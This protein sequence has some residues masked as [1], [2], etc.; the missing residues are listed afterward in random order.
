[1]AGVIL[2]RVGGPRHERYLSQALE[3]SGAPPLLGVV[4]RD[5]VV[6]NKLGICYQK[7]DNQVAARREYRR[8][9][10]LNPDYAEVWNNIG[11]LNQSADDLEDA[12]KAYKEAIRIK[13]DLATAW[14]NL[15]NAYLALDRPKEAFEAYQEAF[16]L[17]P[18]I[19]ETRGLGIPAGVDAAMPLFYLAKL[20]AA[21]GNVDGAL[22]F[23]ARAREAGFDDFDRVRSDPDFLPVV[24]D[25]RFQ[26]LFGE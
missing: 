18:T 2:N 11:T 3:S 4:P 7:I 26:T 16:R 13:P 8:A 20:L 22:E 12:V 5:A 21:N 1:M 19:L 6:H 10:A 23:L 17:D 25:E 24:E 9:L 15:G 14:K